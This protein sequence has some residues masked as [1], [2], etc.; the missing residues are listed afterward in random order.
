MPHPIARHI[1]TISAA[2]LVG[3]IV[4]TIHIENDGDSF[5]GGI[6]AAFIIA[7]LM[8]LAIVVFA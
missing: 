7:L 8:S 5:T 3:A 6:L 2:F 4:G 1:L